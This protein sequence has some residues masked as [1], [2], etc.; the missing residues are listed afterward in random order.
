MRKLAFS[1]ALIS[2]MTQVYAQITDRS[3]FGA[4]VGMNVS[5]I[6]YDPSVNG[7]ETDSKEGLVAG[8]Y[9]NYAI[10]KKTSIQP[11][12]LYSN[13]GADISQSYPSPDLG[14]RLKLEYL[15]VP[16]L[17]KFNPIW[18]FSVFAGPQF[19]F[20]MHAK[21]EADDKTKH[22]QTNN[23]KGTDIAGTFGLE[24]WV[25]SG[26]GVYARY[27][28]GFTDI[29]DTNG[30]D[31]TVPI[32]PPNPIHIVDGINNRALQFGL[33]IGFRSAP[34][35]LEDMKTNPPSL[36]TM[37]PVAAPAAPV[38]DKDT[39]GD[40]VFDSKDKCPNVAGSPKYAGCPIPDTDGDGINDENDKCPKVFGVAK[41]AGCPIPDGDSDGVNDDDDKCPKLAGIKDNLGCPE[42]TFYYKKAMSAL[43]A[44][45]KASLDKVVKFLNE[46]PDLSVDVEGHTSTPGTSAYNQALS[47]RRAKAAVNYLVSKGISKNRLK[48]V[49]Y[50]ERFPIGDNTKEEGKAK[51]RRTLIRVVK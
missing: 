31:A 32:N 41:Y 40:G 27:I 51:S 19:D 23:L 45:D 4:K 36:E 49:G 16:I 24:Y 2:C 28:Y 6:N 17:F 50:G 3:F 25:T 8:A 9:Y 5:Y 30:T 48:A 21:S 14:G 18:R 42:M 15:S 44:E 22:N 47:E 12:L 34:K 43:S 37:A 13:M 11:E 35:T 39:D 20:L 10:S 29:N 26:I 7:L 38:S 1:I 33:T 46:N